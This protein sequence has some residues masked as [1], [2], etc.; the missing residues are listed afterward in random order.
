MMT[1]VHLRLRS[2]RSRSR[3]CRVCSSWSA[4]DVPDAVSPASALRGA[5]ASAVFLPCEAA[6]EWSPG[7][8]F[9]LWPPEGVDGFDHVADDRVLEERARARAVDDDEVLVHH[10]RILGL[11]AAD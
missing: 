9:I 8:S 6:P 1:I 2:T 4:A 10:D 3:T 5:S 11:A 7:F